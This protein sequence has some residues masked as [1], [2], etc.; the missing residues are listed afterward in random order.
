MEKLGVVEEKT[1]KTAE[2]AVVKQRCPWCNKVVEDPDTTGGLL[3]CPEHG[4][5]PFE[6]TTVR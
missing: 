3:K 5:E 4:T 6:S 1:E 2:T